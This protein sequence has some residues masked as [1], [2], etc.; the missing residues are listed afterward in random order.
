MQEW[1][2][3]WEMIHALPQ[4]PT[5]FLT[6]R[7]LFL[8]TLS[9]GVNFIK[10]LRTCFSYESKFQSFSL[11]TFGFVIFGAKIL[12]KKG[13]RKKLMKL[14]AGSKEMYMYLLRQNKTLL[15]T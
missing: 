6:I 9:P 3:Y 8:V 14:M 2:S 10:I 5:L 4:W 13:V 7:A 1:H 15:E 12:Y 11:I